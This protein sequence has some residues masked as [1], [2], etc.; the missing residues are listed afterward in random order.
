MHNQRTES[1]S[2]EKIDIFN[3]LTEINDRLS[4]IH[5]NVYEMY[6]QVTGYGEGQNGKAVEKMPNRSLDALVFD[7]YPKLESIDKFLHE[8]MRRL[9]V[10]TC[11]Q[12]EMATKPERKLS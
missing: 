9:G 6:E 2:S 11:E 3:A 4:R 5:A 8:T 12:K 7:L 10:G 1:T